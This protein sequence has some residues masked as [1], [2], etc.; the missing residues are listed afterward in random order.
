MKI[1]FAGTPEFAVPALQALIDH[2]HDILAVYTQPDRPAGRGRHAHESPIKQL[3]KHYNLPVFQPEKLREFSPDIRDLDKVD[4]LIVAAYGLI[5]PESILNIPRLGGINI[6]GSL[7]P[8]WRGAAPIHRALLA[9][10][11]Q[12][13][14]TI[15]QMDKGLDTGDMLY[16]LSCPILLSDNI[17]TLHTTLSTLGAKGLIHVLDNLNTPAII[18]QPQNNALANYASKITK[19]EANINWTE[20][21]EYCHRQI[22]TFYPA[23]SHLDNQLIKI[24]DAEISAEKYNNSHTLPPGTLLASTK[25]HLAVLAGDNTVLN[26]LKLQLAGGKPLLIQDILNSRADFFKAGKCF[27]I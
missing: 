15:M 17:Q 8:R 12:T 24:W 3:A 25:Q 18:P 4:A 20:K 21:A 23:Y 5:I 11:S 27:N 7:L 13:G 2:H 26:I 19:A 10:D 9:G 14:V 6:H 1:I 22:R 16:T